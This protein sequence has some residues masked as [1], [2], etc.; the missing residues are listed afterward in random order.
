MTDWI[1]AYD[2]I[3]WWARLDP[4]RIALVD[5]ARDVPHSYAALDAMADAWHAHLARLGV[6]AGDRVAVLAGNR[7]EHVTLL[8]ACWRAGA[9]LVPLNWRLAA[10]ELGPVLANATPRVLAG[11]GRF[12]ALAESACASAGIAPHWHD[13]DADAVPVVTNASPPPRATVDDD[14]GYL[15]L[16]TSGSTGTP[17]G[18]VLP[19]RQWLANAVATIAGWQLAASDVAPVTTPLFHTGGW[20]VVA[21]PLWHAGGRVILFDGWNAAQLPDALARHRCTIAFGVPT[22][23]QLLLEQPSWGCP[24][25][26]LRLLLSGGAPCPD[27]VIARLAAAGLTYRQGY[28]LTECGPNCFA[29]TDARAAVDPQCVG[30]PVPLLQAR[31]VNE[32]G[33]ELHEPDAPG[34]LQLRG[35]QRFRE[36]LFDEARTREALADGGWLRTG[37][38]AMRDVHGMYRICG[39]R[40]ELFISGGENVYPGEVENALLALPELREVAVIGVPDDRWGEVGCAFVVPRVPERFDAAAFTQAARSRL[41][42]YKVPRAVRVVDALPRLVSGK[43]DRVALRAWWERE[44]A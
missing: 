19:R 12:R 44:R 7:V 2:P 23:L 27:P 33:T 16:Y 42:G 1:A 21:T 24:L 29:T 39:R 34:E 43:I 18:V 20:H 8:I 30:Q 4:A 14:A 5:D 11:E 28:G 38:L 35:P 6:T 31:L 36:Y 17:K 40:K 26:D 37:D 41:A 32:H 3:A 13:L 9:M 10:A 15:V 25:P 22:Q